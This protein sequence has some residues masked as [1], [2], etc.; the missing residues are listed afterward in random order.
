MLKFGPAPARSMAIEYG[1]L[2]CAIEV[3]DS[4]EDAIAHIHKYG[5]SHTDTIITEN[6]KFADQNGKFANQNGKLAYQNGKFAD[7]NGKFADQNGKFAHQNGKFA[8]QNGA[9]ADPSLLRKRELKWV[10]TS[11]YFSAERCCTWFARL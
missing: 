3:V 6:G 7:Q 9:F 11:Y 5:S 8:Y 1:D 10:L 2:E 4:V